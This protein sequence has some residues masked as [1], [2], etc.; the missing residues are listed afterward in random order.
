MSELLRV[1]ILGTGQVSSHVE[2]ETDADALIAELG[3]GAQD[4]AT[5]RERRLLLGAGAASISRRAGTRARPWAEPVEP[6]AAESRR[7]A[8]PA[9]A[10]L[11][12]GFLAGDHKELLPEAL[13][14]TARAGLRLPEELLPLALSE[15]DPELRA[16]LL[17]VLGERG[18][19]LSDRAAEGSLGPGHAAAWSWA[20]SD[21]LARTAED[22]LPADADTRWAEGTNAERERLLVLAR[23]RDPDRAREWIQSTF[24]SDKPE[25]RRRW[26]E[27]LHVGLSM[28]DVPLLDL[29][30]NDRSAVVRLEAARA[31]W[32]LPETPIASSIRERAEALL[33][34][35]PGTSALR[36]DLP[37]EPFD[38]AL[39]KLGVRETPPPGVGKRQWWLAELLSALP[40]DR[41]CERLG[42]SPAE[43]LQRAA[44]HELYAAL[45]NGLTSA[46]LRFE[47]RAWYA[48]LWDAWCATDELRGWTVPRPLASLTEQLRLEE[49]EPRLLRCVEMQ[50][51]VELLSAL[52]RP[53][54]D[55]IARTF[56]AG[57]QARPEA[58]LLVW[59]SAAARVPLEVVP[60]TLSRAGDAPDARVQFDNVLEKF[61]ALIEVRRRVAREI[62]AH[63]ASPDQRPA[64][65]MR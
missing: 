17:P 5:E 65:E 57:L 1:A 48:P 55:A 19:W 60:P 2:T 23:R 30:A 28:R 4:A 15:R 58:F 63:G 43:L 50:R 35:E 49:L 46:A 37:P 47:A 20:R 32:R 6:A 14:A 64:E 24:K 12:A 26:I 3:F 44:E 27:V 62:A 39:E 59:S 7:R 8:S 22:E 18:R 54:P 10:S 13:E 36:I 56:V 31:A 9:L 42:G 33:G 29:A 53:W 52:P 25:Q 41:L 16:L 45:R 51:H 11:L 34:V 21:A 40:P 38:R 61:S